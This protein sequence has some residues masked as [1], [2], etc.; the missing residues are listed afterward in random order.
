MRLL[1]LMT[2]TKSHAWTS[3]DALNRAMTSVPRWRAFW[4]NSEQQNV[5]TKST[6]NQDQILLW[7]LTGGTI[8]IDLILIWP[9]LRIKPYWNIWVFP[10]I[11]LSQNGWFIMEN[12]I[13]MDYFWGYHYFFGNIH[14]PPEFFCSCFCFRVGWAAGAKKTHSPTRWWALGIWGSSRGSYLER[15]IFIHQH[16]FIMGT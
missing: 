10:K 5:G 4:A 6:G 15:N 16:E 12:L 2:P 9:F 3:F 13:K 11:R 14:I 1:T 8:M 7:C